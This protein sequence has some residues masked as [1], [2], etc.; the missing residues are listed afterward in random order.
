M[1]ISKAKLLAAG[2]E[3]IEFIPH[4]MPLATG[5]IHKMWEADGGYEF[6]RDSD[7]TGEPL[8]QFVEEWM[9][10]SSGVKPQTVFETWQNQHQ[11]ALLAEKFLR[12]WQSTA[13]RT[14]T[15]RPI[16]ALIMPS[17]PFPAIRHGGGYPWHYGAMCPLLDL[18]AGVFPVTKVDLEKDRVPE[19]W[20]P[21]SEKDKEVMGYCEFRTLGSKCS[22]NSRNLQLPDGKP[23]NHEGA[24]IGLTLTAKRLEE[25]KVTAM[26]HVVRDVVG[27]DY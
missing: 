25:E 6:W 15:G 27:V 13:A 9:G 24:L 22:R 23:E 19:D 8:Q 10:Q 14:S 11:R 5:I 12:R 4:E 3:I 2:H 16:D 7:A 17:T 18:T 26:L 20:Q 21:I 1:D